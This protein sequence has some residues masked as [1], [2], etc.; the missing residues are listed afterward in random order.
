MPNWHPAV[1]SLAR[2]MVPRHFPLKAL[3]SLAH[4]SSLRNR[5]RNSPHNNPHNRPLS[6]KRRA[7]SAQACKGRLP[8]QC[9]RALHLCITI[10][11]RCRRYMPDMHL[12]LHL[13]PHLQPNLSNQDLLPSSMAHTALR[14]C[15]L[16]DKL[17][18]E[19]PLRPILPN[20]IRRMR[21]GRMPTHL[22]LHIRH[23]LQVTLQVT[24]LRLH[25]M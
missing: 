2:V 10:R 11:N 3:P 12:R 7:I 20:R 24:L 17:L 13:Q 8:E 19:L 9:L 25:R 1:Q 23:L 22:R 15:L 4:S 6:S 5:P 16:E 18:L 14:A 21:K